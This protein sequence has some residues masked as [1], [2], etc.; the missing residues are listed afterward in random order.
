[1]ISECSA[2]VPP[3][4]VKT[5]NFNKIKLNL[6]FSIETQG[7]LIR[8]NPCL[9]PC[10]EGAAGQ[11]R[12]GRGLRKPPRRRPAAPSRPLRSWHSDPDCARRPRSGQHPPPAVQETPP[13]AALARTAAAPSIPH[14]HAL[15][16]TSQTR[17]AT[18][19]P[20]PRPPRNQKPPPS[21][22]TS[23]QKQKT[24]STRIGFFERLSSRHQAPLV[25]RRR[26]RQSTNAAPK[27][28]SA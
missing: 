17:P 22:S 24:R 11:R 26:T 8:W 9:P 2:G 20:A 3:Y 23:H 15:P 14:T 27:A 19:P 4:R 13:S 18:A 28:M 12:N 5:F 16:A 21:P 10:E 1:V 6:D 25:T 7:P